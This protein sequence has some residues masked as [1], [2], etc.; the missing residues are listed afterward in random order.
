MSLTLQQARRIVDACISK[1]T[2]LGISQAVAV[3]DAA[4]DV[5]TLDRMDGVKLGREEF[6]RGKA[7]AAVFY[8]RP[9]KDSVK[10]LETAPDQYYSGLAMFP[11]RMFIVRGGFPI[12]VGGELA[13]GLGVSGA[14]GEQ[15]E[16]VAMA[17]LA[18][19]G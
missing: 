15:D 10:M 2:E 5:I 11:G 18:T 7:F 19:L 8:R 1:A 3:V 14:T 13:G 16:V 12:E 6:A 4:G 9:T 17:G